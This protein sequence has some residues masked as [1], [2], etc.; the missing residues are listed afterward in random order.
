MTSCISHLLECDLV[1]FIISSRFKHFIFIHFMVWRKTLTQIR[2]IYAIQSCSLSNPSISE[3]KY[4]LWQHQAFVVRKKD[5]VQ[6][7]YD[8]F[9]VPGSICEWEILC[10]CT[11]IH[12]IYS[13][14]LKFPIILFAELTVNNVQA[15]EFQ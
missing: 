12:N 11:G 8:I 2:K 15:Q 7:G 6:N 4:V 1:F 3:A 13:H 10:G 14:F 5:H 9:R